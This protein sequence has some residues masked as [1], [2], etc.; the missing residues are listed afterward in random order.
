[1]AVLVAVGVVSVA[2]VDV[3]VD[4]AVAAALAAEVEAEHDRPGRGAI[5]QEAGSSA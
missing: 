1:V 2:A 4:V 3:A 5:A